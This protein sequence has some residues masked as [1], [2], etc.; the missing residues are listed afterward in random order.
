[1]N[2]GAVIAKPHSSCGDPALMCFVILFC[3]PMSSS[4][5]PQITFEGFFSGPLLDR[6]TLSLPSFKKGDSISGLPK[7]QDLIDRLKNLNVVVTLHIHGQATPY[8]FFGLQSLDWS[9]TK[10]SRQLVVFSAD[11]GMVAIDLG[12][13][14]LKINF[15]EFKSAKPGNSSKTVGLYDTQTSAESMRRKFQE[16]LVVQPAAIEAVVANTPTIEAQHQD[17]QQANLVSEPLVVEVSAPELETTSELEP[18]PE[19]EAAPTAKIATAP[20]K[21]WVQSYRSNEASR[22]AY[23]QECLDKLTKPETR[24]K[25]DN[26]EKLDF[27]FSDLTL[28]NHTLIQA[29]KRLLQQGFHKNEVVVYSG[30][31]EIYKGFLREGDALDYD[32]VNRKLRIYNQK[33][34]PTVIKRANSDDISFVKTKRLAPQELTLKAD[35]ARDFMQ[36][37]NSILKYLASGCS[38]R[39]RGPQGKDL[40]LNCDMQVAIQR[41]KSPHEIWILG[42]E[43]YKIES[44]IFNRKYE[45]VIEEKAKS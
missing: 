10:S 1:M 3:L 30:E 33:N 37:V 22:K 25:P 6:N 13:S 41:L 12:K 36:K 7:L 11:T 38:L 23:W 24:K 31:Q 18:T 45:C 26:V 17:L 34:N 8:K 15:R 19:L 9:V 2:L 21:K 29:N 14:P 42:K 44:P 16:S 32:A 5:D 27:K 20:K 40:V 39:I 43:S 28:Q 4:I 35:S